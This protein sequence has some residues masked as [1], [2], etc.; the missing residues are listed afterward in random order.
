MPNA[1]AGFTI[2]VSSLASLVIILRLLIVILL[3][4]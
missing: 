2:L 3:P 1:Q 4:S